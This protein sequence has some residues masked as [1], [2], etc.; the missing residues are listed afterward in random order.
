MRQAQTITVTLLFIA[1]LF[2]ALVLQNLSVD[3]SF[4]HSSLFSSSQADPDPLQRQAF[5]AAELER[6]A[7]L[8]CGQ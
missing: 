6:Q 1:S 8:S 4:G 7:D 2:F 3:F 5:E